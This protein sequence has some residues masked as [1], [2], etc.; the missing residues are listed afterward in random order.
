MTFDRRQYD[1]ILSKKNK[2]TV[3]SP[4]RLP[5][6][7]A[8][9][10]QLLLADGNWPI[11][12]QMLQGAVEGMKVSRMRMLERLARPMDPT[13]TAIAQCEIARCEGAIAALE[14]A[15]ALP[16]EVMENAQA[17]KA[18]LDETVS[19]ITARSG[20]VGSQTEH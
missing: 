15:I 19:K 2:A 9:E 6:Q 5:P 20:D 11:Y 3:P 17:A 16:K 18:M 1:A 8:V 13:A 10:A 4:P 14:S 7:A 12:Q